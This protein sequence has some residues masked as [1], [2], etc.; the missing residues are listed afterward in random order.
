MDSVKS[1][2]MLAATVMVVS[3]RATICSDDKIAPK[4]CYC[5]QTR[6]TQK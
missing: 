6:S 3:P 1:P 4:H 5:T 2:V